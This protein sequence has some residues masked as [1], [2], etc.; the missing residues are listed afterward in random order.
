MPFLPSDGIARSRRRR[1]SAAMPTFEMNVFSPSRTHRRPR[2]GRSSR[3]DA[4]SLP[5]SGS[6]SAKPPTA[7]PLR[8]ARRGVA[9][10]R[11]TP[12]QHERVRREPLHGEDRVGQRRAVG[13][14]PRARRRARARSR[15]AARA[16]RKTSSIARPS[17]ATASRGVVASTS[18]S[19]GAR[20]ASSSPRRGRARVVEERGRQLVADLSWN[21]APGAPG[22]ADGRA[23][24]VHASY[25][26]RKSGCCMQMA[27]ACA[28][29]SMAWSSVMPV[30]ALEHLLGHRVREGGA[31]RE[32][33]GERLRGRAG[34]RRGGTTRLTR[35][36]RSASSAPMT[37][38]V[39]SSSLARPRPDDARQEVPGA[40]VGAAEA[41]LGEDEAELGR[42]RSRCAS[43]TR[44]R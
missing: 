4:T 30:L 25:A 28:S 31:A 29:A 33:C 41:H 42:R 22:E 13:D 32:A 14:A 8:D 12:A 34:T 43:R 35:P 18:P 24:R 11:S 19:R 16:A 10:Q 40:H 38:P 15:V 7:R 6:V 26:A 17:R 1:S 37:S 21:V 3:I 9:R 23:W 5:A 36:M 39:K 2:G 44:A 20:R 27:C